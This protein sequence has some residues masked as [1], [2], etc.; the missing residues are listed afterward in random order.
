MLLAVDISFWCSTI[1][2]PFTWTPRLYPGIW[3]AMLALAVPYLVAQ[4]RRSRSGAPNGDRR[5]RT[6]RYLS[7]VLVVWLATD[8]PIGLLGAS[9]LASAHMLQYLLYGLVAAPLMLLGVPE[10]MARQLLSKLRAYRAVLWLARP[11]TAG[12]VY[13]VVLVLTHAPATTDVLRANQAGSAVM[14]VAWLL[15][16]LILWLPICSP[17]PEH[18]RKSYGAKMA[19]LFIAATIVPVFP[20]S[21]LTFSE[22][23]LY[24]IYELAPR[25]FGLE[26]GT[27]QAMA[28]L[29]MKVGSIPVIWGTLLVMMMRWARDEGVP[30]LG[31]DDER[32]PHPA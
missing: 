4:H 1:A 12:I 5:R 2:E 23:P 13:N 14:D 30:G 3:A 31:A 7:G 28:G 17:L 18:T 25:V 26:A 6:F 16:G 24:E 32:A 22:F 27:D 29:I 11:L 19:Y 8:W 10:W 21:F 20:A 9:Y 15:S